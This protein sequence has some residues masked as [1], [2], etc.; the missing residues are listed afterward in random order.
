LGSVSETGIGTMAASICPPEGT[1]I[2]IATT[3]D[4]RMWHR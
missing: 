4:D 2:M 1:T 3:A